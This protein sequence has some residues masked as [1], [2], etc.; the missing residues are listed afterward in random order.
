MSRPPSRE[1]L[2]RARL[3]SWQRREL[4]SP[5]TDSRETRELAY[6]TKFLVSPSVAD[7]IRGWAREHMSPDP[8]AGGN[9]HDE[10]RT[11]TLYFDTASFDVFHKRE[12]H[13]R[14]KYRVRRYGDS[15]EIFLERKLRS[16]R[17][18]T[19]RRTSIDLSS[20]G[21]LVGGLDPMWTGHWFHR[22]LTCRQLH[23]VCQLSYVRT[24]RVSMT[25]YGPIR[26]TLDR[27][28]R[29]RGVCG[30]A[31]HADGGRRLLDRDAILELKYRVAPPAM[32]KQLVEEFMLRPIPISKYRVGATALNLTPVSERTMPAPSLVAAMVPSRTIVWEAVR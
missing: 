32:F 31:F 18:L 23:P 17:L 14:A 28:L 27:E 29:A 26:L 5:S 2:R 8:N 12:S 30:L 11:A 19:K 10:Y 6:E 22:R 7:A 15:R 1:A 16:N 21:K 20:V 4:M 25:S 24:A 3:Q 13:G 9:G